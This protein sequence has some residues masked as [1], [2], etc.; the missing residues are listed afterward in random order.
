MDGM[1]APISKVSMNYETDL[2]DVRCSPFRFFSK[3]FDAQHCDIFVH[4]IS[5]IDLGR[6]WISKTILVSPKTNEIG[7]MDTS[8][9]PG[10]MEMRGLIILPI[11]K[12]K[13]TV[14]K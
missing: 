8:E 2:H 6:S 10:I 4:N 13:N 7:F 12:S 11:T 9:I 1:N 3:S 14:P 5:K